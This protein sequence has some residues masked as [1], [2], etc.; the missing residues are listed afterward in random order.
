MLCYPFN[1]NIHKHSSSVDLSIPLIEENRRGVNPKLSDL[2]LHHYSNLSGSHWIK[3]LIASC[4][5]ISNTGT[6]KT[7][8]NNGPA[9]HMVSSAV[10]NQ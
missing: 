8:L 5:C 7:L 2:A 10:F 6:G 1:V 9:F 3:N 4:S